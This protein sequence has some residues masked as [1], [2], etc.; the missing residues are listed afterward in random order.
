MQVPIA[1][2]TLRQ[3]NQRA[4]SPAKAFGSMRDGYSENYRE[5]EEE[6]KFEYEH[7]GRAARKHLPSDEFL[8]TRVFELEQML[9][10]KEEE[11][12]ATL[13]LLEQQ[14]QL[15]MDG[16]FEQIL[17]Q[18][19]RQYQ[20]QFRRLETQLHEAKQGRPNQ[21]EA[22]EFQQVLRAKEE[23]HEKQMGEMEQQFAAELEKLQA[24]STSGSPHRPPGGASHEE[25]TQL[26][27]K[28]AEK[29]YEML[30]M[31]A[32]HE[33]A[34]KDAINRNGDGDADLVAQVA[35]L[36]DALA[37]KDAETQQTIQE[38]LQTKRM[39]LQVGVHVV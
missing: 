5:A 6:S 17:E 12:T 1:G 37:R 10:K 20:A 30:K 21:S 19:E 24:F 31:Q 35:S 28:L 32:E 16:K 9:D 18:K 38:A 25:A 22:D 14:Y 33:A 2:S 27:N 8:Q 29:E 3:Q 39:D 11:H 36:E 26:R 15:S 7:Y 34:L 13:Q 23:E 4:K